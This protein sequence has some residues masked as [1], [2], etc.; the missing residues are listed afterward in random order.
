[1][2]KIIKLGL[3]SSL[4]CFSLYAKPT[5]KEILQKI[6]AL[7]NQINKLKTIQEDMS[8]DLEDRIDQIETSTLIDKINFGLGFKTRVDNF[9]QTKANG[10]K[11]SDNNIWSNIL[12][13]NMS[14]KINDEM[15]FTGRLTMYKNWADSNINIFSRYDSMQG[16]RPNDSK[17]FVERAYIDWK[18]TDGKVPL[19]LTIG[20]QPSSDGPSHQ[21][22]ENT[23]RKSTYSALSFDGAADGVVATLPL[24][25][26]SGVDGMVLRFGYGKGYQ[27]SSNTSY[28]GNP[29]GIKD[30]NV[31]GV[32]FEK[33][34][35][36]SKCWW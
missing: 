3:I 31:L 15:K 27:D 18:V 25:K 6:E 2:K 19:I 35:I 34:N 17:L 8:D 12:R 33:Q 10:N 7:Q 1:M 9:T 28:V 14:S 29:G 30:S 13:L 32:F 23:V 11:A 5:N 21:F 22:K 26:V 24:N 16:R 4:A 36:Y 20:R